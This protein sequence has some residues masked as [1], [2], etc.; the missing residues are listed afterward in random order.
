[1]VLESHDATVAE[2]R[3]SRKQPFGDPDVEL[4]LSSVERVLIA[5]GKKVRER[6]AGKTELGDLKGPTGNYRA[7]M[8]CA[9]DTLLVGFHPDSLA[10][11]LAS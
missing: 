9:G 7:P 1:M 6:A 2:E 5:R 10:D 4:L 11:L 3:N 8:I